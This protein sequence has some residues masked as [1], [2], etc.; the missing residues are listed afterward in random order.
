V[1]YVNTF[2]STVLKAVEVLE[3]EKAFPV[4]PVVRQEVADSIKVESI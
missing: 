1:K 3:A 4:A 2:D